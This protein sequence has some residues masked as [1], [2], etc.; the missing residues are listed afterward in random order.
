LSTP[1]Y[2]KLSTFLEYLSDGFA[3][4]HVAMSI[5]LIPEPEMVIR[6][7]ENIDFAREEKTVRGG[8]SPIGVRRRRDMAA[9]CCLSTRRIFVFVIIATSGDPPRPGVQSVSCTLPISID[10][11]GTSG[12]TDC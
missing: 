2:C 11:L 4:I 3:I 9:T 12:R 5:R 8:S 7:G 10:R 1:Q 6:L